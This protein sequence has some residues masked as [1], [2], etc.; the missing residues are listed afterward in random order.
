MNFGHFSYLVYM[1]IFT[2]LPTTILWSINFKFL[3]RNLKIIILTVS[4]AVIYQ[5]IADLI[6]E[7]WQ[8]WFF[9]NDKILQI[10]IFNFPLENTLF[11]ILTSFATASAVLTFIHLKK[12][13]KIFK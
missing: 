10:W 2:M 6:A 9:S 5:L 11:F 1:L 12:I 7:N 3:K 8:A 13:K 4:L